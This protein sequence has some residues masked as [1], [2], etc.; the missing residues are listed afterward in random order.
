MRQLILIL[1]IL[2]TGVEMMGQPTTQPDKNVSILDRFKSDRMYREGLDLY[3]SNKMGAALQ[4][5]IQVKE[6]NPAH[7]DV[8]ELL[9]EIYYM[10]GSYNEAYRN[11]ERAAALHPDNAKLLNDLG[12]S[13]AGTSAYLLA[14]DHFEAAL[15]INPEYQD[16][17]NNLAEARRRQDALANNNNL[18]VEEEENVGTNNRPDESKFSNTTA[19]EDDFDPG[20]SNDGKGPR[21]IARR[22]P[23]QEYDYSGSRLSVGGRTD[24]YTEIVAVKITSSRT[25]ITFRITNPL[26]STFSFKL[27]PPGSADAWVIVDSKGLQTYRLQGYLSMPEFYRD[28]SVSIGYGSEYLTAYFDRL[29][30]DVFEF[31]LLEGEKPVPGAWNF[32]MVSLS[33]FEE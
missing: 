2:L 21:N 26:R 28:Q 11:F 3:N 15:K 17:I 7:P 4:K 31:N 22:N 23:G 29:A 27:A 19:P 12:V 8:Y 24:P 14:I 32:Y 5:F 25:I 6:L 13:A 9:G 33:K 18:S 30:P 1:L 20:S 10:Q 16:A